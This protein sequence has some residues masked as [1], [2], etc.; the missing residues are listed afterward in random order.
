MYSGHLG[1]QYSHLAP[2]FWYQ[3]N[4]FKVLFFQLHFNKKYNEVGINDFIMHL[5]ILKWLTRQKCRLKRKSMRQKDVETKDKIIFESVFI[6]FKCNRSW[7]SLGFSWITSS[8][9][10]LFFLIAIWL[11]H[12]SIEGAASLTWFY[13]L[14]SY[15]LG[16][17]VTR[18]LV[19]RLGP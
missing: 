2:K 4:N 3:K 12:G 15:I 10:F 14:C 19:T 9:D 8:C 1:D 17:K 7:E 18:S 11:P 5:L 6:Y 13:S 16:L